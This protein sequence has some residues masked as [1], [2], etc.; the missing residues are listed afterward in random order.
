MAACGS[1]PVQGTPEVLTLCEAYR[2]LNDQRIAWD[3]RIRALPPDDP[4]REELWLELDNALAKMQDLVRRLA[5]T[6][7]VNL[8]ELRRK[9]T[10]LATLLRS[11]EEAGGGSIMQDHFS[12]ALA[13]SISDDIAGLP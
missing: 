12:K 9:A 4:G 3:H 7:A 10:V 11:V 5:D 6:P 2:E 13:L 1:V 8:T